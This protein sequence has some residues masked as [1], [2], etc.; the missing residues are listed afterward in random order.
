[1]KLEELFIHAAF[2]SNQ[3]GTCMD[4]HYDPLFIFAYNRAEELPPL[5][6]SIDH[7][8]TDHIARASVQVVVDLQTAILTYDVSGCCEKCEGE[9][10]RIIKDL[11]HEQVKDYRVR[12]NITYRQTIEQF[13]N[14]VI[15]T[16]PPVY[17]YGSGKES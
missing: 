14:G 12:L 11:E 9:I 6:N 1:M 17:E 15:Q 10:N 3:P 4:D 7:E 16:M 5:V 2:S 13:I 8:P